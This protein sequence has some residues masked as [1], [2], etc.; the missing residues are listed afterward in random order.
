MSYSSNKKHKLIFENWRKFLKEDAV[1]TF[2]KGSEKGLHD[3]TTMLKTIASDPEFRK[4]ALAGQ[5][6]NAGAA[7]EAIK[8]ESGKPVMAINLVPTQFDIDMEKSLGDQMINRF[9]GTEYALE[10]GAIRMGSKEGRIPVLV[11]DNKYILDG[12]H[13]WSQVVMTNPVGKVA[14]DNLSAPAFGSGPKGAELALKA[15]QLGIA[16]L[17]GNVVTNDTEV[18]LLEID[19]KNIPKVVYQ[20]HVRFLLIDHKAQCHSMELILIMNNSLPRFV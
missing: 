11:F 13:R 9:N 17:A 15:T 1:D 2:I 18:N 3:Y 4:L 6:D 12:H 8:V 19:E 14:V 7:D 20:V 5:T 10:K 16:G